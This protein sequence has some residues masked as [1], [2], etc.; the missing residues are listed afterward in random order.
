ME[1]VV[2]VSQART[3][4]GSFL[5][6]LSTLSSVE[7][8]AY[9]IKGCLDRVN[10]KSSSIDQL[11]MGQVLQGGVGQAPARQASL[12]AG[13]LPNVP[14][15]TVN[16]VCGSGLKAVMMAADSV[17]LGDSGMVVAG[18][19]ESMS[20]APYL[21]KNARLGFRLGD[22]LA[23]DLM[24]NDGLVDPY[25]KN[26][27]GNFGEQCAKKYELTREQQDNYA[28][29]SYEKAIKAQK[30]GLLS[31][32]IV[33][34]KFRVGRKEIVVLEDEEIQKYNPE[35]M[36]N[37]KPV[38]RDDGTITAA[39]ASKLNDGAS[40]LLVANAKKA[41]ELNLKPITRIISYATYAHEP[42]WFTTAPVGAIKAVLKK[43]SMNIG[44]VDLFEINEAF[45]AVSM[46]AIK[47]LSLER[48]KIN[49]FGGAVALGHPL[50]CSGARILVTLNNAL[51]S[52]NKRYGLA[53]LCLGGG[54]AVAMI[55]ENLS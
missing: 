18:G 16:K 8:G 3:P 36:P 53:T 32:E 27:M 12:N 48:S 42:E 30:Q 45:S 41:Q 52:L 6:S 21:L 13:L 44:D 29:E 14:C 22:S 34:L 49:V 54:E 20:N 26:H 1:D 23:V 10:V 28:K 15:T 39:N 25:K 55:V 43:A 11:I 38:F 7:L 4:I 46:A 17:K 51:T 40:A 31:N 50:G 33:P 9:A 19:M 35:K 24:L 47:E 5:G 37:L 2:I